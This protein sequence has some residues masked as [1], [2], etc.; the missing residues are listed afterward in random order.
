MFSN[1]N[2]IDKSNKFEDNY[3]KIGDKLRE[4]DN[5]RVEFKHRIRELDQRNTKLSQSGP[6]R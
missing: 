4:F 2:L 3:Y 1:V 5:D 6:V